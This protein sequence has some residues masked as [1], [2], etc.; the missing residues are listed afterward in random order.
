MDSGA[1]SR[2][3]RTVTVVELNPRQRSERETV[4]EK[5]FENIPDADPELTEALKHYRDEYARRH[6]RTPSAQQAAKPENNIPWQDTDTDVTLP[7]AF[8]GSRECWLTNGER[9]CGRDCSDP[10]HKTSPSGSA[11]RDELVEAA[12]A[13]CW[14]D[15]SDNDDDAVEAI[16]DL[17]R[18]LA[19]QGGK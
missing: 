5:L 19:A 7:H 2:L 13:V 15:W 3:V 4:S 8:F 1:A 17:R 6:G 14:F 12:I 11:E 18:A 10:I 9:Q 16:E